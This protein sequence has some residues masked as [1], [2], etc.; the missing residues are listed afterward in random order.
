[1]SE[2]RWLDEREERAWRSLQLMQMRLNAQLARDLASHS[3][4]SFQDYVVLVALTAQPEGRL[5]LF[6]LGHQL[7]WE[8]SRLSHQVTRMADRGLVEKIKCPSDLRGAVVGVSARGLGEISA[9]AP[10]H[11]EAVRRLF[12]DLLEAEQLDTIA[13]VAERV[14]AAVAE[15]EQR[16]CP[17]CMDGSPDAADAETGSALAN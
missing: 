12:V 15:E 2:V 7:G 17:S 10:G 8:K 14:L 11:L 1:M 5:R 4:L 13:E 16:T 6:E 9:A 3:E